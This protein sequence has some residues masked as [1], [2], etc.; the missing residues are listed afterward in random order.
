MYRPDVLPVTQSTVAEHWE[1]SLSLHYWR[2]TQWVVQLLYIR[3]HW[4]NFSIPCLRLCVACSE[5]CLLFRYPFL[6]EDGGGW[7]W[8]VWMEWCP[9]GW[10]VCLPLLIFRCTIKSRSSL[11]A[12]VHPG[13]PGKRAVKRVCVLSMTV[14]IQTFSLTE[15]FH[16]I[17]ITCLWY[18]H[19]CA[20]KGR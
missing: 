2:L 6:G 15:W 14:I 17:R 4:R 12:P 18:S 1:V 20:E 16:F 13:G 8:L 7:H 19:I 9:A 10:S 5:K 3:W 11:L